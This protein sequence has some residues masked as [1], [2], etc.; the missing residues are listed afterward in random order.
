MNKV[1]LDIIE[2]SKSRNEV[3]LKYFGGSSGRYYQLLNEFISQ[4]NI[5]ASHLERKIKI[6]PHCGKIVVKKGNKFCNSSC[7]ASFT[8]K[9]KNC[10]DS[11][12]LKIS[13]KLKGRRLSEE[14]KEKRRGNV[15]KHLKH[16]RYCQRPKNRECKLCNTPFLANKI[17]R[18]RNSRAKFC[19]SVCRNKY[20]SQLKINDV[21][22]GIHKGWESRKVISY[23]ERFFM[24]VLKNNNINYEHNYPV[25]KK[26]L[27]ID[28]PY[29]YFL[30]F[31][32][33]NKKIDLEVDG[34][35][36]K[37][38]KEHDDKRD[39]YLINNGFHVYRIKWKSIN[40]EKGKLYIKEEIDKFM[41]FYKSF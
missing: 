19:S 37:D 1:L 15:N 27:G 41:N 2:N 23:P 29:S 33:E 35:Q 9:N 20:I 8:N 21:K 7:S 6:C 39:T 11:T 30:D 17:N 5:D 32:I 31:F 25:S 28:E 22:N 12:K 14:E 16:G 36:H 4:N 24:K 38:R 26:E 3:L 18:N 40:T 34:R 10:S 13:L